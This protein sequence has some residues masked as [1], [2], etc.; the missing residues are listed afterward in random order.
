MTIP[1]TKGSTRGQAIQPITIMNNTAK[2]R[3]MN[4]VTVAELMKSRTDSKARRLAA[5]DPA[6][7]G[8]CS[9]RM[10]STRSM[11]KAD[12]RT[13]ARLLARST[14][15]PRKVRNTRSPASTTST[16]AVSTHRVSM[17]LFGTT[18]SYTFMTNTGIA[19][20]NRLTINAASSTSR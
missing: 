5:S 7:A 3:S 6:D 2:G 1:S 16:P 13:S 8:L 10:P 15:C 17:A 12:S 20:A 4:A 14:K 19:S 18:R 9:M 11:M